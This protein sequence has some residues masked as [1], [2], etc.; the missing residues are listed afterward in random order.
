MTKILYLLLLSKKLSFNLVQHPANFMES[1]R[2]E[3]S[4]KIIQSNHQLVSKTIK[5]CQI[6]F[7][8]SYYY[9]CSFSSDSWRLL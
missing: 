1:F 3:K 6:F 8:S 9:F 7:F 2:L 4:F 5:I